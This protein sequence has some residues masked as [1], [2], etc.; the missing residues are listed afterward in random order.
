MVKVADHLECDAL[1]GGEESH[2]RTIAYFG[3]LHGNSRLAGSFISL[4]PS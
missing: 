4:Q 1:G 2:R 3:W